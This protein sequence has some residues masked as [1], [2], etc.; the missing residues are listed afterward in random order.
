MK[1]IAKGIFILMSLCLLA[2]ALPAKTYK[3]SGK[4]LDLEGK[5]VGGAE[6]VLLDADG[7]EIGKETTKKRLGKGGFGLKKLTPELIPLRLVVM[8]KKQL[9]K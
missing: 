3:I 5:G 7:E 8:E 6:V 1:Q 9:R 2:T 4:I